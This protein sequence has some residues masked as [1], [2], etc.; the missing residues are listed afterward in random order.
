MANRKKAAAKGAKRRKRKVKKVVRRARRPRLDKVDTAALQAELDRRTRQLD[1]LKAARTAL[2][3]KLAGLDKR[4]A[5]LWGPGR[6]VKPRKLAKV[7]KGR[8]GKP[9]GGATL[10]NKMVEILQA[11]GGPMKL[12]DLVRAVQ[13]SDYPSKSKHL[14]SM[15]SQA[16]RRDRRFKKIRRGV[17][18]AA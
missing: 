13:K 18:K 1:H 10:N 8:G 6:K 2:A 11:A 7:R 5:G 12:L 3:A 15:I 14:R 16:L 17:Y 9:R 4:I